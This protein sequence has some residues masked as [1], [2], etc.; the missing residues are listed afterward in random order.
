MSV[1][2]RCDICTREFDPNQAGNRWLALVPVMPN[3]H[4]ITSVIHQYQYHGTVCSGECAL[5]W[6]TKDG[7]VASTLAHG[8]YPVTHPPRPVPPVDQ[9]NDK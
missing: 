3:N 8:Y 4:D 5:E 2:L 9:E 1:H 6:L 7:M